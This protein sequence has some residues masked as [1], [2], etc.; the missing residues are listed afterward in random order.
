[1]TDIKKIHQVKILKIFRNVILIILGFV[2]LWYVL[3]RLF[4][5]WM[6]VKKIILPQ[7]YKEFSNHTFQSLNVG[8]YNIAHGRGG[9]TGAGNWDGGNKIVKINRI[10]QIAQIL[11]MNKLDI[12]VLNEVDFSC[13]WSGQ[14]DQAMI[15]A[16]E[17]GYNYIVEQR[18]M[19]I[20]IPFISL[21][22][23]NA[24]L[25]KYPVSDINFL[26]YP[27]TS[28]LLEVL[29]SGEKKGMGCI[30]H[31]PDQS[32]VK[33]IAVHLSVKRES[34]RI[35]SAKI[36]LDLY[37][38][39]SHPIIIMGDFNTAIKGFPYYY[40]DDRGNNTIELLTNNK[41]TTLPKSLP[42]NTQ[43]LTFPSD[44]PDRIIDWILVSSPWKIKERKVLS[45]NLSDHLPVIAILEQ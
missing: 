32:S 12:V 18:N 2:F 37:R 24:I 16:Q 14:V 13:V 30:V 42:I 41:L 21:K 5:P 34:V 45:S 44:K 17:A 3:N 1:M 39:S 11:K 28:T 35:A 31:L 43:D 4:Y 38:K 9:Q 20:A 27:K 40:V 33:V 29:F 25:S 26:N 19:D 36:I 6:V 10:K 8:C 15:I 22:F 23:G 7:E